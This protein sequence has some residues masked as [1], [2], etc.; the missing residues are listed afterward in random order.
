MDVGCNLSSKKIK[1]SRLRGNDVG[2]DKSTRESGF[3]YE[4][5]AWRIWFGLLFDKFAWSKFARA[6]RARSGG[7]QDARNTNLPGAVARAKRARRGVGQDARNTNLPGAVAR[8]KRARRAAYM[9]V[10]CNLSSKK[11]K[12]SRVRGND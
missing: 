4:W 8:S 3:F 9:D 6:K 1:D 2:R 11:I 12:D 5:R 7:G 10:G